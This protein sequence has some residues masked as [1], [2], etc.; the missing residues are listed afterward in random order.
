MTER[1]CE[2]C[3][4]PLVRKQYKSGRQETLQSF[5]T[6]RSCGRKCQNLWPPAMVHE[7]YQLYGT[8]LSAAQIAMALEAKGFSKVTRNAVIGKINRE[9]LNHRPEPPPKPIVVPTLRPKPRSDNVCGWG[10][11]RRPRQPGR[12]Y[13]STHHYEV[14]VKALPRLR[15]TGEVTEGFKA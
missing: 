3:G 4:K 8:G 6:R 10:E 13:C 15:D 12:A 9:G 14:V 7:L 5:L 1:K 11:C 2:G